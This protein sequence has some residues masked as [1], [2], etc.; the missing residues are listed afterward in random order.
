MLIK[1]T[2]PEGQ[3]LL[4]QTRQLR[5]VQPH[6]GT[7]GGSVLHYKGQEVLHCRETPEQVWEIIQKQVRQPGSV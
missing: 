6:S 2:T 4:A 7:Y 1:L 3:A 5:S